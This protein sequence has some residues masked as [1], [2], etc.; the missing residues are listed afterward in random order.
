VAGIEFDFSVKFQSNFAQN[1]SKICSIFWPNFAES[2]GLRFP[3]QDLRPHTSNRTHTDTTQSHTSHTVDTSIRIA[4]KTMLWGDLTPA[5]DDAAVAKLRA[6]KPGGID[7]SCDEVQAWFLW[8]QPRMAARA[9]RNCQRAAVNWFPR[10]SRA[11]IRTAVDWVE[12]QALRRSHDDSAIEGDLDAWDNAISQ[13]G[14]DDDDGG[15]LQRNGLGSVA[16]H[17]GSG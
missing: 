14:V 4:P 16:R 6:L 7:F 5:L 1:S 9:I 12:A 8:A 2:Q 13:R 3:P 17:A 15:V 10:S 11:E